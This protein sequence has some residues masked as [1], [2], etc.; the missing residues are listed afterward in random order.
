MTIA[1]ISRQFGSNGDGVAQK[2]AQILHA[3]LY[4]RDTLE[5]AL[6]SLGVDERE[7]L[8]FDERRPRP[9]EGL[10]VDKERYAH[11][12]RVAILDRARADR[13][14]FVGRGAQL[15]LAPVPEVFNAR[16]VAPFE[17]R[18]QRAREEYGESEEGAR[19]LVRHHDHDRAGFYRFFFGIDWDDPTHYDV[20]FNTGRMDSVHVA[21]AIADAMAR[22]S[23]TASD[24][25]ASATLD[26]LHLAAVVSARIRFQVHLP[27]RYLDVTARDGIV[28]LGGTAGSPVQVQRCVE[29]AESVP[30]VNGVIN[31]VQVMPQYIGTV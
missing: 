16:I 23:S 14:V 10:T 5:E 7:V 20:V 9:W 22:T 13:V 25:R 17:R 3:E 18:V 19:R 1:T 2:L 21:E 29:I 31:E 28:T 8:L 12:L 30:G 6:E 24:E 27:P 26:D 4:T 11:F 15:I